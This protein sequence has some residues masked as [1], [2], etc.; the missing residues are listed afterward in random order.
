MSSINNKSYG[1]WKTEPEKRREPEMKR[2]IVLGMA[3]ALILS[4]LGL[5]ACGGGGEKQAQQKTSSEPANEMVVAE[6]TEDQEGGGWS[7][8]PIYSGADRKEDAGMSAAMSGAIGGYKES[9]VRVYTTGD[10][11]G[12]VVVYYKSQMP[13]K[14]WN[15]M[16]EGE[17]QE[18]GWGSVWQK[19]D[20][21]ILVNVSVVKDVDGECG[22]IIARH[23]GRQ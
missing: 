20:G 23:E 6:K 18:E 22:I 4:L 21:Q 17:E 3:A 10:P 14:G 15:K 5:W 19:K 13:E 12:Q 2:M 7:D 8:I 1:C 16:T 9:E 11:F